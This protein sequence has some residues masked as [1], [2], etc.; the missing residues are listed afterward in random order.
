MEEM[1][2][3]DRPIG[4]TRA[5]AG[6]KESSLIR[7]PVFC[8]KKVTLLA[9]LAPLAECKE[10]TVDSSQDLGVTPPSH[11]PPPSLLC[12]FSPTPLPWSLAPRQITP[13]TLSSSHLDNS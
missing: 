3:S 13:P 10:L 4:S 8:N 2:Q 7:F 11:P 6:R 12:A 1:L 5:K 9:L